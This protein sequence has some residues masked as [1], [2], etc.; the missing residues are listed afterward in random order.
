MQEESAHLLTL[1]RELSEAPKVD[2]LELGRQ[3]PNAVHG[4]AGSG[5][6]VRA[7]E[8]VWWYRVPPSSH[9]R[10]EAVLG[11]L[12]AEAAILGAVFALRKLTKDEGILYQGARVLVLVFLLGHAQHDSTTEITC[13]DVGHDSVLRVSPAEYALLRAFVGHEM[14]GLMAFQVRLFC[15][16]REDVGTDSTE[17]TVDRVRDVVL[18]GHSVVIVAVLSH[19]EEASIDRPSHD[20]VGDLDVCAWRG[21]S[22]G[23]N[24]YAALRVRRHGVRELQ[25][26]PLSDH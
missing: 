5:R 19:C 16:V 12:C 20:I 1:G 3:R 21:V 7:S 22:H 8:D 15:R 23:A 18:E 24:R 14:G 9:R 13:S 10:P 25:C 26:C 17:A 11:D 4:V 2:V 6:Q